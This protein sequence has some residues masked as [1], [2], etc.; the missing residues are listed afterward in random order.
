MDVEGARSVE[1][2]PAAITYVRFRDVPHPSGAGRAPHLRDLEV[3]GATIERNRSG[4]T[5]TLA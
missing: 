4:A 3:C 2:G 5:P 1:T